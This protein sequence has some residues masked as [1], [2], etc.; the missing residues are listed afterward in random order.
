MI[1]TPEYLIKQYF[2]E[3]IETT[4]DLYE[5]LELNEL[6]YPYLN[7]LKDLEEHCLSKYV[8]D[9]EYKL[10][11]DSEKNYWISQKAFRIIIESSPSK[12][13]DEIRACVAHIARKT[14]AD[15]AFARQLQ[16]QLDQESGLELVIPKVSK[17]LKSKYNETGKDAFEFSVKANNR[18][19]MDII[20]GYN[21]QPGQKIKDV[22]FAFK[23]KVESGVPYHIVEMTLSLTNDHT[24]SYRTIWCCSEERQRYGAI[25]TSKVIRIN[26]FED[27]KKPIDSFDYILG[28]SEQ[29]NLELELEKVI[30]MLLELD[31]TEVDLDQ[32]GE[33]I[34]YRY[35]LSQQAFALA[36]KAVASNM[37]ND[38]EKESANMIEAAFIDAVDQYWEHYVLQPNPT[39]DL[40]D[41]LDQMV[42]EH[43]PSI[44][45]ALAAVKIL[46]Y[47]DLCDQYFKRSYSNKQKQALLNDANVGLIFALSEATE[48]DPSIAPDKRIIDVCAFI[49]DQLDLMKE[50]LIEMGKWPSN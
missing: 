48:F 39:E 42:K 43:I 50:I 5:R 11:P 20:S 3:P 33:K 45:L 40:A 22:I 36:I 2:P 24:L 12:I 7:W 17:K 29:K 35:S 9:A 41:D 16:D 19:Y 38:G 4:R 31:L 6:G 8:D 47:S 1:V 30:E 15:P 28:P 10:L 46:N 23:L 26:L 34:L 21:F 13:G 25:L 49:T 14:A 27:N 18:L 44:T 32:L 37:A